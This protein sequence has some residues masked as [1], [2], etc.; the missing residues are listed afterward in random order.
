MHGHSF[1]TLLLVLLPQ[2]A[3]CFQSIRSINHCNIHKTNNFLLNAKKKPG[4]AGKYS[5]KLK[6]ELYAIFVLLYFTMLLL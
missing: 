5:G 1:I 6:P 3:L 4:S 2:L